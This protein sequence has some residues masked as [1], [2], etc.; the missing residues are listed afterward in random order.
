MDLINDLTQTISLVRR[1]R[2]IWW[3]GF[4]SL[5][6]LL[7]PPRQF[8]D[9]KPL[10]IP[11]IFLASVGSLIISTIAHG[12]LIF[13]AH[14]LITDG[15]LDYKEIWSISKGRSFRIYGALIIL[16][17]YI[18]ILFVTTYLTYIYDI[19]LIWLFT[20]IVI[21]LV[22]IGPFL[23]FSMCGILILNLRFLPAAKRS[24]VIFANNFKRVVLIVAVFTILRWI[25]L[26]IVYLFFSL[27]SDQSILPDISIINYSVYQS[28]M[29]TPLFMW[30]NRFI[31]F[32]LW[33]FISVLFT[34]V[35][36]KAASLRENMEKIS[37]SG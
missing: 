25:F 16:F 30:T 5:I 14:Q 17:P 9:G 8:Y 15:I 2:M 24:I 4:L 22:I 20:E 36:T 34:S 21:S 3:F 13:A 27:I 29:N 23:I 33:P 7:V 28:F 11:I 19:S 6:Y 10:L 31:Y 35:F 18:L 26:I 32:L 12:G 1:N 37:V